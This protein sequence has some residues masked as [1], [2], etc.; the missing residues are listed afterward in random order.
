MLRVIEDTKLTNIADA[1]REKNRT[2]EQMTVDLMPDAIRAIQGGGSG[3]KVQ[4]KDV[5]FYDYD[6]EILYSYTAAE[7]AELTEMPALPTREGLICQGWNQTLS[8]VK[9]YTAKYGKCDIGATYITDDGK[10]RLYI[11]IS[12][13][14]RMD[15]PLHL[16]TLGNSATIEIDWGDGSQIETVEVIGDTNCI[17]NYSEM[18]EY[19][20]T[21]NPSDECAIGSKDGSNAVFGNMGVYLNMLKKVEIGENV[22]VILTSAFGLCNSLESIVIPEGVK[23]IDIYSFAMCHSLKSIVIP[24]GAETGNA[25]YFYECYMLE[26]I[27]FNEVQNNIGSYYMYNCF[28]LVSVMIPESVNFIDNHSFDGCI[29]LVSIIIPGGVT[30][31]GD[32]A[33]IGCTSMKYYDFSKHT[34]I[35]TLEHSDAFKNIP[36]DCEIRVPATLAEAWKAATNWSNY[37]DHIVGV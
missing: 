32:S 29:N 36:Y 2:E 6:G 1:I 18:G 33:F 20:I 11:K 26:N 4:K 14:K 13:D 15:L 8:Y 9:N 28:S 5:N 12:D 19:I 7:T 30:H 34:S 37:A 3:E 35:P 21:L 16:T 22:T 25:L 23:K 31:I 10:T 27:V 17:H 24:K